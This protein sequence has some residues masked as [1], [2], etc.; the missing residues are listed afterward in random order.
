MVIAA[1]AVENDAGN[2]HVR[3]KGG[4]SRDQ[5]G[6]GSGHGAGINHEDDRQAEYL[7]HLGRGTCVVSPGDAIEQAHD[8][9]HHGHVAAGC[10]SIENIDIGGGIEHPSI[11]VV[12]RHR[13]L[14]RTT[15]HGV[16]TRI[17]EVG[18][19]L[20][21]LD[22]DASSGK[23]CH[24]P[25]RYGRLAA[26]AVCSRYDESLDSAHEVPLKDEIIPAPS[27]SGM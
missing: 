26:A 20:E 7:R 9:F 4:I 13:G 16:V 8:T 22:M 23:R 6:C 19:A 15:R 18:A 11:E 12:A 3:V 1:D 17:N 27:W 10:V 25:K 21:R 24:N 5:C 14:S 2:G